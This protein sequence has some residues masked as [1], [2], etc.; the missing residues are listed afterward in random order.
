MKLN[1]QGKFLLALFLVLGFFFPMQEAYAASNLQVHF[2]DVGQGDASLIE[3]PNGENLLI[4]AGDN[5]EG[6]TVVNYIQ[7]EGVSHLEYVVGTHPHADHI[8]GLDDVIYSISVE[9]V[10]MPDKTYTSQTYED[11]LNAMD[12][13]GVSLYEAQ[14]GV[15][16]VN[17][18]VDGKNLKVYMVAPVYEDDYS[19]TNNWSTV[20]KVEYG[21]TSFLF[22]G[23]AE[24]TAEIDMINTGQNLNAD[25]LKVGHHG[26]DSSSSKAFLDAVD[27]SVAVISVGVGNSYGHPESTVINRLKNHVDSIYRTDVNGT[28]VFTTSGSGWLV[29][30]QPW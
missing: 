25:I 3:L 15:A 14:A 17:Q 26:S 20:I 21:S 2:I 18:R 24:E 13:R 8:G 27:P 9:K 1:C 29:N 6:D 30:K 19:D 11:V 23:D 7:Q 10:Y 28:V 5:Y 16:L 12:D 22:T 4:D